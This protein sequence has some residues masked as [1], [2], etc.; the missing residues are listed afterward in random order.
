MTQKVI[1][2]VDTT[3]FKEKLEM[4]EAILPYVVSTLKTKKAIANFLGYSIATIDNMIADGRLKEGTHFVHEDNRLRFVPIEII[5]WKMNPIQKQH[6][7]P[8]YKPSTDAS[9]YI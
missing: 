5:K 7:K 4:A 2:V 3:I 8:K 6:L 9:K 1:E